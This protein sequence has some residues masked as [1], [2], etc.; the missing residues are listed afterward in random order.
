MSAAQVRYRKAS[1]EKVKA[2]KLRCKEKD[3]H[4]HK[5]QVKEYNKRTWLKHSDKL[6]QVNKVWREANKEYIAAK[7]AERRAK[8]RQATPHHEYDFTLFV[9]ME[10]KRLTRLREQTT[11]IEWHVDHAIP[12]NGDLVCGFHYWSNFQVIPAKVNLEKGNTLCG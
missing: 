12:L 8:I 4:K 10:A 7:N 1:P 3:I 9:F 6:K 11:G 2:N 5:Q